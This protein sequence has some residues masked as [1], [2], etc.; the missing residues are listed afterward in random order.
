[1]SVGLD[2]DPESSQRGQNSTEKTTQEEREQTTLGALYGSQIPDSAGEPSTLIGD[3]E[4]DVDVRTM[5][6][7]PE[8]D[9]V[10]WRE[11]EVPQPSPVSVADLV[12]QLSGGF[13]SM[14]TPNNSGMLGFDA[15]LLSSI[16]QLPIAPEQVQ[17][18]M[19]QAQALLSGGGVPLNFGGADQNWTNA[20]AAE[21]GRGYSDNGARG[22]WTMDR[23]Q[24][25]GRGRG[26]GRG[27][28]GSYRNSKR[29]PCSFFAEG[30]RA[31]NTPIF[32]RE[33]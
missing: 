22:R 1:M 26:R 9:N 10:F 20:S 23:G 5:T 21:Y 28:D 24:I 25:R 32:G 13:D 30:R 2:L 15:A 7:G 12:G 11:V 33:T 18:L 31:S 14:S 6:V 19:Q 4:I 27:E 3:D 8:C 16:P 17:E 29:K